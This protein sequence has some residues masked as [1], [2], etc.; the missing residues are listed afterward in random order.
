MSKA[1]CEH[2]AAHKR[3]SPAAEQNRAPIEAVL[4]ACFAEPGKVLELGSGTG[5]HAAYFSAALPR[6]LW[7]P[8]D[9]E[10]NL[11]SIRAWRAAASVTNLLEPL[12][13]DVR[14][15]DWPV[16]SYGYAFTANTL[17]I[18]AWDAVR[19]CFEGVGRVLAPRGLFVCYGPY[20]YAGAYTSQSN[21][22]FDAWLRA[23]DPCSGVRDFE[24]L[25]A[26]AGNC[27][28]R[29]QRDYPMPANNHLLCWMK[30]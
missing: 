5:Q 18:M 26:L 25:D 30:L 23:R 28:M 20:N 22:R 1:T 7:Q 14:S 15:Q 17:H 12:A 13:L 2:C 11:P 9:L 19:A 21:A 24:A 10:E 6:L 27:G 29:L 16:E 8:T 4:R 3:H